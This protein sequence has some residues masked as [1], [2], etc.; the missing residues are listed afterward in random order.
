MAPKSG[1]AQGTPTVAVGLIV[2]LLFIILMY[3]LG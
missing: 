2:F 1:G 3:V